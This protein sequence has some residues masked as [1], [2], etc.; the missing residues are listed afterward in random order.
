M[1]KER[2]EIDV[3][4]E[5]EYIMDRI[6]SKCTE[7]GDCLVWQGCCSSVGYPAIRFKDHTWMVRRLV[8]AAAGKKVD[9]NHVIVQTCDDVNCVA[10]GHLKTARRGPPMGRK[11]AASVSAKMAL[12]KQARSSLT[13]ADVLA[14]RASSEPLMV[15]A[16]RYGKSKRA[17]QYIRSGD[18]WKNVTVGMWAGLMGGAN[19]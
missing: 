14:I 3:E 1:G 4:A 5:G 18:S 2:I 12:I 16:E 17:I 13:A 11:Q 6:K 10:L 9:K 19:A 8:W 15:L 7:D